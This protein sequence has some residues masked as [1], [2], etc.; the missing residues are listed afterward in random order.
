MGSKYRNRV[1]VRAAPW[2]NPTTGNTHPS[3]FIYRDGHFVRLSM[4][5]ARQVVDQVHDLCDE[6]DRQQRQETR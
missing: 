6:H 1:T 5:Q 2:R 3:I 4:V